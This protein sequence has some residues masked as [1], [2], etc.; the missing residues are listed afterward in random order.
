MFESWALTTPLGEGTA[1]Q[2]VGLMVLAFL[3]LLGPSLWALFA[4]LKSW[5]KEEHSTV[6]RMFFPEFRKPGVRFP[7]GRRKAA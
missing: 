6:V 1:G 5:R 2:W 7:S 3:P 4:L